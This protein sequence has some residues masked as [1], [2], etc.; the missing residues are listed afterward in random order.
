MVAESAAAGWKVLDAVAEYGFTF[1]NELSPAGGRDAVLD[2]L[3]YERGTLR[4]PGEG[5]ELLRSRA[6]E[7]SDAVV[8]NAVL[9]AANRELAPFGAEAVLREVG[10]A[11]L[12]GL[13]LDVDAADLDG[14][15]VLPQAAGFEAGELVYQQ[16]TKAVGTAI[17]QSPAG[18]GPLLPP[19]LVG[20]ARVRGTFA[21]GQPI[22]GASS[23]AAIAAPAFSGGLRPEDVHRVAFSYV[24]MRAYFLVGTGHRGQGDFGCAF[25]EHPFGFLDSY[26]AL[27]FCDGFAATSAAAAQRVW[28]AVDEVRPAGS[29][30]TLIEEA[31]P[32]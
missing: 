29:G 4:A 26:P 22:V 1:S 8:P 11:E 6:G 25:D 17:T 13:Y 14:V 10:R 19:V 16:A 9:R 32:A 12:P 2:S 3:A 28:Q 27:S 24:D 18:L 21:N 7:P 20:I 31:P 15:A 30:F 5:D 23:G